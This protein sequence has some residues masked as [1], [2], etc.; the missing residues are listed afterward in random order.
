L[1]GRLAGVGAIACGALAVVLTL[2]FDPAEGT[3]PESY[4]AGSR[5]GQVIGYALFGAALGACVGRL[6]AGGR[7]TL[8]W[9]VGALAAAAL[10]VGPAIDT[11]LEGKPEEREAELQR[12]ERYRIDFIAGCV[13][14]L[15]D[16][17]YREQVTRP[18][19]ACL[20]STLVRDGRMT[21]FVAH[22]RAT[23]RP[24][25]WAQG[26]ADRCVAEVDPS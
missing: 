17:G 23:G 9:W 18:Y 11:I 3:G 26:V 16:D 21:E 5:V 14:G 22:S 24:P 1:T 4:E 19:C 8:L 20:Y 12:T 6:R 7:G 10:V 13:D 25:A 15:R 2:V